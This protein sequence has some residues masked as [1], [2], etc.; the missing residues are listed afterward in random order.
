MVD[1]AKLLKP[2]LQDIAGVVARN[3][4]YVLIL[5]TFIAL[6]IWGAVG[7][8]VRKQAAS[9]AAIDAVTY[10]ITVLIVSR[11]CS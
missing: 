9:E 3:F 6:L 1:Q 7:I 4:V 5:L 8:R 10:A 11:P 2:K